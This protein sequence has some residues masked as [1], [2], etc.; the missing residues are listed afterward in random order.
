MDKKTRLP[1]HALSA[2]ETAIIEE[3]AGE[4]D[5]ISRVT[6]TG[7]TRNAKVT[8]LQNWKW[9]PVIVFIRDTQMALGRVEAGKITVRTEV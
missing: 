1:L 3:V 7:F 5:F 9:E 2:G 6:A 8:M 4:P